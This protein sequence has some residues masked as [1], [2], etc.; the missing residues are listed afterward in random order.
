MVSA[1][2]NKIANVNLASAVYNVY[3][4]SHSFYSFVSEKPGKRVYSPLD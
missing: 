3:G 4:T 1:P 2:I